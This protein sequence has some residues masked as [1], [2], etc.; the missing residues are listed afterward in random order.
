MSKNKK[1]LS[2]AQK[3]V[4][5]VLEEIR[6]LLE[7]IKKSCSFNYINNTLANI[8]KTY[9]EKYD[10]VTPKPTLREYINANARG[11]Y[12]NFIFTIGSNKFNVINC[13]E[14]VEYGNAKLLDMFLV[15]DD[16]MRDNCGGCDQ[17]LCNHYLTIEKIK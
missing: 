17:Y 10:L 4:K 7:E 11:A 9:E 12:H 6:C 13:D 1:Q 16:D 5:P 2:E 3:A 8:V 14:F 15:Y